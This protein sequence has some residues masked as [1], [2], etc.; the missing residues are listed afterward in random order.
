MNEEVTRECL[1]DHI[2]FHT[3]GGDVLCYR[4]VDSVRHWTGPHEAWVEHVLDALVDAHTV[5]DVDDL[6]ALPTNS[7]VRADKD[8]SNAT[9]TKLSDG[10]WARSALAFPAFPPEALVGPLAGNVQIIS[11]E[12]T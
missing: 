4:R 2:P 6:D 1:L 5:S 7:M 9:Y 8:S 11:G 10:S 12:P 3:R